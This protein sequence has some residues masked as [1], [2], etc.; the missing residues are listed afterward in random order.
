MA[1]F[2]MNRPKAGATITMRFPTYNAAIEFSRASGM[3][4]ASKPY[5]RNIFNNGEFVSIWCV[6][7]PNSRPSGATFHKTEPAMQLAA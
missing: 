4:H 5:K 6:T 3:L 7:M 2:K 1:V